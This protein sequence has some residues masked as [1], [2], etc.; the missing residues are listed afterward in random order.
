MTW[1]YLSCQD[2]S[3]LTTM[4]GSTPA[5]LKVILGESNTEKLTLPNGIPESPSQQ[6]TVK[7]TFGLN[8]N[9][10]LQYMDQDFGNDF[11]NLNST[12]ELQ[13][14]GTIK[15]NA[16]FLRLMAVPLE[17]K[18]MAQ[19]DLHSSQLIRVIR[20]KGG[21]TRQKTADIMETLDKTDDIHLQRECVLKALIIFL[22]E[23][24]DDLIKEY[25]DSGARLAENDLEQLTMT[26]FVIWKEGEGVWEQPEDIGIVIEG[27][28]V[29]NEL[30]SV[31]SG[32]VLLLGLIYVLNLAYP[33]PLR[34]TFEVLQKI[35]VQLAQ[36]KMS[37][38]VQNLYGRLQGS[39]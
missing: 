24:A 19:L 31:T 23:D 38:K 32:C 13:D 14:L 34:F 5:R 27:V 9:I 28:E 1:T 35:I 22:G 30:T 6:D 33:K 18:F 26:V 12:T 20:A 4:A 8:G 29:L 37:P 7:T 10:R 21:A 39:Q 25:V 36:H 16:E 17:E 2:W 15:I 11:F 3:C